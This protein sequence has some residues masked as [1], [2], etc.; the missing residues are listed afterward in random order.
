MPEWPGASTKGIFIA[1]IN[2]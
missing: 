2:L 1:Y